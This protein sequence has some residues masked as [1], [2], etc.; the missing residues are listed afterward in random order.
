[1]ERQLLS[2]LATDVDAVR[3]Y[4]ERIA[5]FSW[6]DSRHEAMAWAMLATPVGSTPAQV[7][8]AATEVVP[9]APRI[10]SGGRMAQVERM[11]TAEKVDF[12][13]DTVDLHSTRRQVS[14]IKARLSAMSQGAPDENAQELFRQA[15]EL[16]R[17]CN[18][19]SAKLSA[20]N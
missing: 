5:G 11:T 10:L 2:V 4:G 16:Q 7:V 14:Q 20:M 12:L 8:A 6:A 19:L 17:R 1:M 15:T 9:E 3:P 13:I 18:E